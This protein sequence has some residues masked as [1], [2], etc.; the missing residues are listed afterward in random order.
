MAISADAPSESA[1]LRRKAHYT[2]TFLSD[3][4]LHVIRDYD[5]VHRHGGFQEKD[6]ARPAEFL[7][8]R[9]RVVRWRNLT[10]DYRVRMRPETVF[11]VAKTLQ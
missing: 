3:P 11:E 4:N 6:I 10:E 5:L 8:D 1:D 9:N 2:Y 7:I